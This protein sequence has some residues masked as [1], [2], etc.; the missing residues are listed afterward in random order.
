MTPWGHREGQ[1]LKYGKRKLVLREYAFAAIAGCRDD[2]AV[3]VVV[4]MDNN[5][6]ARA[7]RLDQSRS[8]E[9][10]LRDPATCLPKGR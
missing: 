1:G 8:D 2:V 7:K 5:N 9:P 3:M 10:T 4:A 6:H